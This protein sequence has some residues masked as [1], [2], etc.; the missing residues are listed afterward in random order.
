MRVIKVI[1]IGKVSVTTKFN[2]S[3]KNE[4][5]NDDDIATSNGNKK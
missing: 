5:E 2:T 1:K 3:A 4:N